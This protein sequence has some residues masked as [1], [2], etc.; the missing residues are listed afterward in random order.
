MGLAAEIKPFK[1]ATFMSTVRWKLVNTLECGHTYR[2]ITK[3]RRIELKIEKTHA[4]DAFVVAGGTIQTR[5]NPVQIKQVRRNNGS[6]QKF[7]DAKYV[8]R[9]TGEKV[10]GQ[11]LNCGRRTRNKN[12]NTEN[13]RKYRGEKVSSGRVSIRKQRYPYQPGDTVL[14]Q[15][16]KCTVKGIQKFGAYVKLVELKKPVKTSEVHVLFYGKGLRVYAS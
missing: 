16:Q 6:L 11:E 8:D 14:Y 9:R 2:Y 12:L 3:T 13:L 5:C 1:D 10:S 15:R 7:Y 4:N